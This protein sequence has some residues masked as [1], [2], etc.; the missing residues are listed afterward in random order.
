MIE[1]VAG[2]QELDASRSAPRFGLRVKRIAFNAIAEGVNTLF[3]ILLLAG[4]RWLVEHLLGQSK[5]FDSVPVRYFL[6]L[7]I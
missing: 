1:K 3:F 2:G 6:T 4:A 7:A 5:F